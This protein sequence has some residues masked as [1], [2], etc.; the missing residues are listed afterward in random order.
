VVVARARWRERTRSWAAVKDEEIGE[1][2]WG[3]DGVD[4]PLE[5]AIIG[6]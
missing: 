1:E 5:G 4:S 2:A 6:L 3:G